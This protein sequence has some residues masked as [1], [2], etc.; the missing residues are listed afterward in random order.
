MGESFIIVNLI[1][2]KFSMVNYSISTHESKENSSSDSHLK[3]RLKLFGGPSTGEV[4]YFKPDSDIIK[5]GRS[6]TCDV[7]IE[8]AVLSKF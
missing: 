1:N 6:N 2:E 8:D 5:M 4:F 7:A 3:L